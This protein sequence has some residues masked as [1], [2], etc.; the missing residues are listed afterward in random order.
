VALK[1]ILRDNELNSDR[2]HPNAKGCAKL[3]PAIAALVK[4][5]AAV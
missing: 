5:S 2:A 3:A 1:T 4:L